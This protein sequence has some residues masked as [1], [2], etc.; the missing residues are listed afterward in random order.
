MKYN[1][2]TTSCPHCKKDLELRCIKTD[3]CVEYNFKI[4]GKNKWMFINTGYVTCAY[5]RK[6]ADLRECV[7]VL[8]MLS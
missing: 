4:N 5:C 2:K 3:R 8:E 1:Y 7:A 6:D